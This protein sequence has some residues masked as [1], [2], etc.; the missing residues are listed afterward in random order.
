MHKLKN[1]TLLSH[2]WKF[3]S[4]SHPDHDIFGA[5]FKDLESL[6]PPPHFCFLIGTLCQQATAVAATLELWRGLPS[7]VFQMPHCSLHPK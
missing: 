2:V 1:Q 4:N 3:F 5:L 7:G 6:V